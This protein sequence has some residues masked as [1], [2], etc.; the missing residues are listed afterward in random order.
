MSLPVRTCGIYTTD[1]A[2]MRQMCRINTTDAG[3]SHKYNR[4]VA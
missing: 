3:V 2:L 4:C 1:V